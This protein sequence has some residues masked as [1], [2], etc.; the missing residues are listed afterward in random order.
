MIRHLLGIRD[1][2]REEIEAILKSAEELRGKRE[3]ILKDRIMAALFFEASTRTRFSFESAMLRLGGGILSTENGLQSSSA[4]KG[5]T[6]EDTAR[7]VSGYADI[8]VVRHP[9]EGAAKR[10][11]AYSRVP[12]INAGDG[13]SE[14]PTQTLTDL[15]TIMRERGSIDG[16]SV[17]FVGD[18]KNGRTVKSLLRSLALF[19]DVQVTL[20]S[21]VG[22]QLPEAIMSELSG[23]LHLSVVSDLLPVI[24]LVDVIYQTRI[25]K[26]R[27]TDPGEYEK[28]KSC[29]RI[30]RELA[31]K[32]KRESLLMHPLPR[33]DEIA[34]DVD[35][36]P[37]AAYFRQAENGVSVRMALL[38]FLLAQ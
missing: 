33:I 20:V 19:R 3:P 29:Y 38:H 37:Q 11:A 31:Q 26:E 22:L 6:L 12:V 15:S 25:Q 18:L 35:D 28:Y 13:G 14:H 23:S 27:F 4:V 8:I 5:E 16:L 34:P 32:M 1:F 21:P 36:L 17:A 2:S 10:V 24:S 9:E 7:I 30:D